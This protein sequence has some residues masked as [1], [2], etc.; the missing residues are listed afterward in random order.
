MRGDDSDTVTLFTVG[1]RYG[2]SLAIEFGARPEGVW[3]RRYDVLHHAFVDDGR[4]EAS[5]APLVPSLAV[6][7]RRLASNSFHLAWGVSPLA[8]TVVVVPVA[9]RVVASVAPP[10]ASQVHT[11]S[12]PGIIGWVVA[13]GAAALLVGGFLIAQ[14]VAPGAPVIT[15][16]HGVSAP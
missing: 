7:A 11:N 10:A 3:L 16:S 8:R 12:G 2:C 6:L 14:S 5:M 15:V 9:P 13:G 4:I 1:R